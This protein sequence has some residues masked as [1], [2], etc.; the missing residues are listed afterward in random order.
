[1][2]FVID[3]ANIDAATMN[4]PSGQSGHPYS[5]YYLDQFEKW[6]AGERIA[7]PFS[8]SAINEKVLSTLWLKPL[9]K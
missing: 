1:M 4:L 9:Q 2:R 7:L 3:F 8:R 5:P 6:Y